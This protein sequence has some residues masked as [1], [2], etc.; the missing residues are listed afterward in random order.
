MIL[1]E[2]GKT[3]FT[4][5]RAGGIA[6]RGSQGDAGSQKVEGRTF[7]HNELE[8]FVSKQTG[9]WNWRVCMG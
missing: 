4:E 7:G 8:Y 2:A 5:L 3:G 1:R 9:F 6:V